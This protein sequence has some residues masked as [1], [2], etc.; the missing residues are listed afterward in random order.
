MQQIMSTESA[1]R[2]HAIGYKLIRQTQSIENGK[3]RKIKEVSTL[4][5]K[6]KD[7]KEAV[8]WARFLTS[9]G[10][11]FDAGI[12]QIHSTNFS[13]YGLTLETVFDPCQNIKV[14]ARILEDCYARALQKFK[15]EATALA[16][17]ISCYQSGDFNTGFSTGYVQQVISTKIPSSIS[18]QR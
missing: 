6:P 9:Q 18:S 1:N 13:Q 14:G 8:E 12:A 15:V 16:A 11:E 3:T 10:W 2:S 7:T 4:T 17:A 5:T